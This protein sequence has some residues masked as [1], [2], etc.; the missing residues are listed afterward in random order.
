[1][2][3]DTEAERAQCQAFLDEVEADEFSREDAMAAL[4]HDGIEHDWRPDM[5]A[6]IRERVVAYFDERDANYDP[7]PWCSWCGARKASQCHCGP[8][9]ENE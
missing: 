5:V 1:M 4:S 3:L 2:S 7:T 9:A 8:I 6:S